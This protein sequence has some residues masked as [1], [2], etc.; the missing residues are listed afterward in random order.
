MRKSSTLIERED[1][2]TVSFPAFR[3][4][5]DFLLQSKPNALMTSVGTI[6]VREFHPAW[7][8]PP[9]GCHRRLR[10]SVLCLG[11]FLRCGRPRRVVLGRFCGSAI[12]KLRSPG[13]DLHILAVPCCSGRP[14]CSRLIASGLLDLLANCEPSSPFGSLIAAFCC[15]QNPEISAALAILPRV[16][17]SHNPARVDY[18]LNAIESWVICNPETVQALLS[19]LLS[20]SPK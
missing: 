9:R 17:Q 2:S 20:D 5:Y 4:L 1:D 3:A 18:G 14:I 7:L 19:I 11:P 8:R 12:R 10:V 15:R 13:A 16:F 6:S